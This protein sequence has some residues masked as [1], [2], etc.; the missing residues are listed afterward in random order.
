VTT[1]TV[2]TVSAEELHLL[3]DLSGFTTPPLLASYL[4]ETLSEPVFEAVARELVAHGSIV[5][6]GTDAGPDVARV[7][8]QVL[9]MIGESEG[10]LEAWAAN[11]A[12][13]SELCVLRVGDAAMLVEPRNDV[14]SFSL[15][16]LEDAR[17]AIYDLIGSPV[18]VTARRE[19]VE[20][21]AD[22]LKQGAS[23]LDAEDVPTAA[24]LLGADGLELVGAHH[25]TCRVALQRVGADARSEALTWLDCGN[26]GLYAFDPEATGSDTVTLTPLSG[27]EVAELVDA[28]LPEAT[29]T[30]AR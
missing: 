7:P 28:V 27:F 25:A 4:P 24:A 12:G 3:C 9:G 18:E 8:A 13:S 29:A 19:T 17:E 1:R 5:G 14:L 23:A 21:P 20:L 16:S 30:P 26:R 11:A 15:A 6:V 2:F 10:G 22:S